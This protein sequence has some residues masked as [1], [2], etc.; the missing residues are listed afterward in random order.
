MVFS[1]PT[2]LFLFLPVVLVGLALVRVRRFQNLWLL[3]MSVMFYIWGAGGAALILL[4]VT[5]VSF[6]V[7]FLPWSTWKLRASPV[8][9]RA[10]LAS[11]I[12][13][14][15]LPILLFKYLPPIAGAL[16][17]DTFASVAIPLGISFFTFHAISYVVD[18]WRGTIQPERNLRDFALYLFVFPHQIAGPIVRY[19]EIRDELY[20]YRDSSLAQFGYGATRFAW[21]LA[22]KVIVADQ[23]GRLANAIFA[24]NA[25]GTELSLA[26]AWLG[27]LLYTVQIYF[28]FSGYSDM[29][30]GLAIILGFHFP[31]NF[32]QPYRSSSITE[33]WRR[34][35]MT[36]SRWF[37]DYVYFPLGGNRHGVARE[38]AALLTVFLLTSLWHGGTVNFLIWGGLHSAVLVVERATGL[39]DWQRLLLLRRVLV[40][41]FIVVSWVPFRT[42]SI[43]DLWRYWGSMAH[44]SLDGLAPL[45]ITGLTPVLLF[46]LA[47]GLVSL[48]GPASSTG[49]ARIFGTRSS[50]ELERFRFRLAIPVAAVLVV[51]SSVILLWSDFS[52]FL[53]FQF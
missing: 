22:K 50:L 29:A 53:Y 8:L 43:E 41:V 32:R 44:G 17:S 20:G 13:I 30:I 19:A 2:F 15:L 5:V 6:S 34:W 24:S 31:E 37:R 25:A 16:G 11:A 35:H 45:A 52:P 28:D 33:F 3:A 42:G 18:V 26:T 14:L 38:Y 47:L 49:F 51:A 36:L 9:A 40:L 21:G 10:A 27:A 7:G 1:S 39:R 12:L 23:V 46:A 48:I 4:G